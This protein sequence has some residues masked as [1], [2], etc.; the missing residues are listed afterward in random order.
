MLNKSEGKEK[1]KKKRNILCESKFFQKRKPQN[2]QKIFKEIVRDH[3]GQC[4]VQYLEY[5][6]PVMEQSDWLILVILLALWTNLVV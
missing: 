5:I 1:K 2:Y 4:P 6:R 3:S